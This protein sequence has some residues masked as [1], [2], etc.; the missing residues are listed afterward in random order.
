[1]SPSAGIFETSCSVLCC[2]SPASAKLSPLPSSTVVSAR[3]TV[4]AGIVTVADEVIG[5]ETAPVLLS[6]LTSGRTRRL[7]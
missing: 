5:T 3:L 6:W 4:S 1:M 7:I 2:I